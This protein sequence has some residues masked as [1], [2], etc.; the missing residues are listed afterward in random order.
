MIQSP[1]D[2][3]NEMV[4]ALRGIL[5]RDEIKLTDPAVSEFV[6]PRSVT[7]L[8]TTVEARQFVVRI[9]EMTYDPAAR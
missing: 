3:A 5:P 1:E 9:T 4:V 6:E 2:L 8:A 7:F